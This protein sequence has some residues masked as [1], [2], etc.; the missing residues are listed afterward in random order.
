[1]HNSRGVEIPEEERLRWLNAEHYHNQLTSSALLAARKIY[2]RR[3]ELF[4]LPSWV[5]EHR[6]DTCNDLVHL[7]HSVLLIRWRGI[8]DNGVVYGFL[9][10]PA[11]FGCRV[12]EVEADIVTK[13]RVSL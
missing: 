8:L 5:A 4:V 7:A 6:R 13:T 9:D 11:S 1:M 2:V 12:P 10:R 3:K